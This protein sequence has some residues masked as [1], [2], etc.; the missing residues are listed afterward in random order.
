MAEVPK[1]LDYLT[2]PLKDKY[3]KIPPAQRERFEAKLHEVKRWGENGNPETYGDISYIPKPPDFSESNLEHTI[4]MLLMASELEKYKS[5][6]KQVQWDDVRVMSVVHDIGEIRIGDAPSYGPIRG[7]KRWQVRK[8]Y[9]PAAVYGVL[10]EI[11]DPGLCSEV[12]SLYDR[13]IDCDTFDIEAAIANF[14]DKAQGTLLTGPVI[15]N[16]FGQFG[17]TAPSPQLMAHVTTSLAVVQEKAAAILNTPLDLLSA[18]NFRDYVLSLYGN[19]DKIAY[20]IPLNIARSRLD[21][22]FY[23]AAQRK[24]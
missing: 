23:E 2:K 11:A 18:L 8:G 15:F 9:E 10:S 13:Y 19:L 3:C 21:L 1:L 16:N 7:S 4:S 24:C 22:A 5:I 20:N 17:D 6:A 12:T 14:L